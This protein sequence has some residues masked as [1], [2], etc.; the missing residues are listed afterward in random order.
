MLKQDNNIFIKQIRTK[1]YIDYVYTKF[2]IFYRS[3]HHTKAFL[4]CGKTVI[5][6]LF[7]NLSKK[8]TLTRRKF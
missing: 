7:K 4:Y 8:N 1:F 6:T 2:Y 5:N 3:L